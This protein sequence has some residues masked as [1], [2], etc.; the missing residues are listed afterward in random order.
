MKSDLK[1]QQTYS[2]IKLFQER[3][4]GRVEFCVGRWATRVI[5]ALTQLTS[6]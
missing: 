4:K 5:G 6:I 2:N 1:I 3:Q